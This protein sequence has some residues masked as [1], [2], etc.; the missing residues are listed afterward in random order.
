MSPAGRR[1]TGQVPSKF[2]PEAIAEMQ[3]LHDDLGWSYSRIG[4]KYGTSNVHARRLVLAGARVNPQCQSS[5]CRAHGPHQHCKACGRAIGDV[6][7]RICAPCESEARRALLRIQGLMEGLG[8]ADPDVV[9]RVLRFQTRG[10]A[11]ALAEG[12]Q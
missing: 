4:R 1:F 10:A 11:I 8:A 9:M 7:S 12:I 2:T 6:L 5:N 3:A